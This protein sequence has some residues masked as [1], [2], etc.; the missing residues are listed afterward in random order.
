MKQHGVEEMTR[1]SE[2]YKWL[3]ILV[4]LLPQQGP[5]FFF[6]LVFPFLCRENILSIA[7]SSTSTTKSASL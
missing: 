2:L 5:F 6:L 7:G 3:H 1:A 4:L